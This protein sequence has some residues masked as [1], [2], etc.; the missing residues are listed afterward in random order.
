MQPE[1]LWIKRLAAS[2]TLLLSGLLLQPQLLLPLS[3]TRG[4]GAF[5]LG[6]PE[7]NEEFEGNPSL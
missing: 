1:R 5:R 4:S 6:E 7:S 3:V 2:Y